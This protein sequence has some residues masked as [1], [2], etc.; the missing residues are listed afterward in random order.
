MQEAILYKPSKGDKLH[1]FLCSQHCHIAPDER[2]YCGVRENRDGKL[3]TLVYGKLVARNI[4]PVEKK[5]L[6]HFYPGSRSYSI[7]TMGCNFSCRFCQNADIAQGPKEYKQV[8]GEEVAPSAIVQDAKSSGCKSIA[9]T[10]TE[11]T[12]FMEYALDVAK[13]AQESGIKNVFVTNGYMSSEALQEVAPYLDAANVDL[14]AFNDNFYS[15]LCGAHLKPVK[16]TIEAMKTKGVWI[17][18]TTL[19]IPGENDDQKE[20]QD[21]AA[22][23]AEVG[24]DIPWH[25]SAFHPAYKMRDHQSTSIHTMHKAREIGLEAGLNYVYLGNVRDEA[26]STTYC[27]ECGAVLFDRS[28]YVA[29]PKNV[30]PDGSCAMCGVKVAGLGM[31]NA[32]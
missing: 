30:Q 6:Y 12:I 19:L 31:G 26:G 21:L 16:N 25:I 24:T 28:R 17:E 11:P 3:Y 13:L 2:G 10:Y 7:G 20:L 15:Q 9:Y 32:S 4:D 1:C 14:K 23:L 5:P 8:A 22:F 29:Q 18:V 27:H